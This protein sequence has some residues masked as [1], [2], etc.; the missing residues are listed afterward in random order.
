MAMPVRKVCFSRFLKNNGHKK[1]LTKGGLSLL[2]LSLR[3]HL[4]TTLLSQQVGVG[5]SQTLDVK[6]F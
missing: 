6:S 2:G 4:F 3:P 5:D 1:A